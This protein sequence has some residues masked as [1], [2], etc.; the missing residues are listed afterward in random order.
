[1]I[2]NFTY[3]LFDKQDILSNVRERKVSVLVDVNYSFA[4]LT[5]AYYKGSDKLSFCLQSELI[6][7]SIIKGQY[8]KEL[9]DNG[10]LHDWILDQD[11]TCDVDLTSAE[12]DF[13]DETYPCL[14]L[15]IAKLHLNDIEYYI[16]DSNDYES[17]EI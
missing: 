3:S 6:T 1:M 8:L 17:V 7:Q 4:E 14:W 2:Y 15:E 16:I 13:P 9:Y 11:F 10:C 5:D 12:D